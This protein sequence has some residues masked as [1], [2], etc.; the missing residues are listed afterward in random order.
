MQ[1]I[2]VH[3]CGIIRTAMSVRIAS[4]EAPSVGVLTFVLAES[5]TPHRDHCSEFVAA[6]L[7]L[8]V[9]RRCSRYI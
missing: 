1:T 3:V 8:I 2:R 7:I 6:H 9:D 5:L 4:P